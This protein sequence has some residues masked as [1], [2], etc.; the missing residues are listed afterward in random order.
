MNL[1]LW[2]HR[3]GRHAP[4][5]AFDQHR[6]LRRRQRDHSVL[7]LRPDEPTLLKPLGEKHETL[8]IEIDRLDQIAAPAPEDEQSADI[9]IGAEHALDLGHEPIE[10]LPHVRGA[11]GE[12]DPRPGRRRDHRPSSA[13]STQRSA[14][15]STSLPTL[16]R[17]PLVNSITITPRRGE[18]ADLGVGNPGSPPVLSNLPPSSP[19]RTGMNPPTAPAS[20]WR[21]HV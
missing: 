17:M 20:A 4:V 2:P 7:R 9:G 12:E 10:T 13:A 11:A 19:I 18:G 8:A 15:P 16:R 1:G 5:D 3:P 6:Q 14:V 21:L